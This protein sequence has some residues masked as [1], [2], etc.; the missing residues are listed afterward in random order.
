MLIK[1]IDNSSQF[2]GILKI[3]DTKTNARRF[4]L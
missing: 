3:I 4:W 2:A 1:Q